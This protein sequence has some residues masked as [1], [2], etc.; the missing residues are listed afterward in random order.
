MQHEPTISFVF[1]LNWTSNSRGDQWDTILV[2]R[3]THKYLWTNKVTDFGMTA[4]L[5]P[6]GGVV[7][8]VC[9]GRETV[10][11]KL[12]VFS[13]VDVNRVFSC[14]GP[15]DTVLWSPPGQDLKQND[16]G[17][18]LP[19]SYSWCSSSFHRQT[20]HFR[21]HI[22]FRRNTLFKAATSSSNQNPAARDGMSGKQTK[23]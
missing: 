22:L 4:L 19:F 21:P 1:G 14:A 17:K 6:V 12:L 20:T 5:A 16:V 8:G 2:E 11:G 18:I 3:W 9:C 23:A 15:L 13:T 7:R 10:A